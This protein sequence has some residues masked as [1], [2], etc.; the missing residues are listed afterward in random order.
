MILKKY[1][2]EQISHF[3]KK[4]LLY[5]NLDPGLKDFY[6][7]KPEIQSFKDVIAAKKNQDIDRHLLCEVLADQCSRFNNN[8]KSLKNIELLNKPN[9]FTIITAHQPSL[10]TGPLYYIFKI[11]SAINLCATLANQHKEY[12]F[13]PLFITGGEDHDFE[14]INHLKVFKNK[15]QWETSEWNGGSVGKLNTENLEF[16]IEEVITLVGDKS[17][18]GTWL[19]EETIPL[20]KES[21]NYSEFARHLTHKIFQK[22]GLVILSMD[23]PRLKKKFSHI[24]QQEVLE[25]KSQPLVEHTQNDLSKIGWKAQAHAREINFFYREQGQ[26]LRIIREGETYGLQGAEK[27]WTKAEMAKEIED[28]PGHFSPNVIMRPLYQESIIPNLAYIGGG[29]EIA[30]WLE[31]KRQFEEFN[32]PFPVLIRRNSAMILSGHQSKILNKAEKSLDFF[33]HPKENLTNRFLESEVSQ[34]ISLAD[35]RKEIEPITRAIIDKAK[36]ADPT[37]EKFAKAEL[38][39]LQKSISAIEAKIKKAYKSKQ[40]IHIN[41]ILKTHES[42]FPENSLQ[43]RKENIFPL[44]NEYGWSL[45]DFLVENLDP[46][47]RRL[48]VVSKD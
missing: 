18:A 39:K 2:Y 7:W 16:V 37:L 41:R 15:I 22:F 48:T 28:N 20:T 4:D 13:I 5:I 44:I 14:E 43:E 34:E 47:D 40:E 30:Y 33:F 32:L 8:E 3:S 27:K 9:S 46:L 23:D 10:L 19:K 24:I 36:S 25:Q 11:A 21:T 17:E 31:R 12:N 26:R 35:Y 45:I 29:G 38:T 6:T 42:I 1:P